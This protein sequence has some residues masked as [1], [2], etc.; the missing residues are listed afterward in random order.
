MCYA[1]AASV[2]YDI[3]YD[4][5]VGISRTSF[6]SIAPAVGSLRGILS[7]CDCKLLALFKIWHPGNVH[8]RLLK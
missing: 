1:A 5:D 2:L 6:V 8:F 7:L 4:H 3:M